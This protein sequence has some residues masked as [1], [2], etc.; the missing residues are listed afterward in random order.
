MERS[1][2]A[3]LSRTIVRVLIYTVAVVGAYF[4]IYFD[5][6]GFL[7]AHFDERSFTEWGQ[8]LAV[9]GI[10]LAFIGIGYK[11]AEKLPLAF[12]GGGLSLMVLIREYN[13]FFKAHFFQG[14][15]PMLVALTGISTVYFI[16]KRR[17][18]FIPS[19]ADFLASPAFGIV[20]SGLLTTFIFSRLFGLPYMWQSLLKEYYTRPVVRAAEE[21]TE[22]L[23][24]LFMFLGVLEYALWLKKNKK[25]SSFS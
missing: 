18:N 19:L 1:E 22:L 23:G 24:Y 4:L 12:L 15:W 10:L 25:S 11:H 6:V 3:I 21:G 9:I 7:D 14:A 20:L 17:E 16:L 13:N 5:A 8:E 2:S